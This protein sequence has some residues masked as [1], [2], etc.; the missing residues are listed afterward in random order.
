VHPDINEG[1]DGDTLVI[2]LNAAYATLVAA[3]KSG[4]EPL[5]VEEISSEVEADARS[6]VRFSDNDDDPFDLILDT[7]HDV[8]DVIYVSEDEGLV[9]VLIDAGKRTESI[10]LIQLDN[11]VM[12][13]QVLFTLE[14]QSGDQ[15]LDIT[16]VVSK[17]GYFEAI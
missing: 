6:V 5:P 10:L 1:H 4:K 13:I 7:S 11:N 12:P 15:P 8:G 2:S 14:L 3:T 9:Q 17:F 16:E